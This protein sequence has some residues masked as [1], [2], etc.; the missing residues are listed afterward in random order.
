MRIVLLHPDTESIRLVETVLATGQCQLTSV[1][2][3]AELEAE[4]QARL[5]VP[6][7]TDWEQLLIA[8]DFDAVVVGRSNW[9]TDRRQEQLRKLAAAGMPLVVIHPACDM[10][11]GFELQM[12]QQDANGPIIPYLSGLQ[13]PL[14][15]K[16]AER[17]LRSTDAGN[18]S[19]QAVV[20]RR[21]PDGTRDVVL[22]EFARDALLLRRL[23][24]RIDRL[25]ALGAQP[26][27]PTDWAGLSI[28]MSSSTGTLARWSAVR[29][30]PPQARLMVAGGDGQMMLDFSNDPS[31]WVYQSSDADMQLDEPTG[32]DQRDDC[33]WPFAWLAERDRFAGPINEL[34]EDA[35]RA[36]ELSDTVEVSYRRGKTISLHH[37]QHSEEETFKSLMA[38]GGCLALVATLIA[39][40]VLAFLST[41]PIFAGP[42]WDR[43]PLRLIHPRMWP[44]YLLGLLLCF[45]GL[46]LFRLVFLGDQRAEPT[47]SGRDR[48]GPQ[49]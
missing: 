25:S 11:L 10:L 35:C 22:A 41:L 26:Y 8:T 12:I 13:H 48:E 33:S 38:A 30:T 17:L 40:P 46:Q 34:W 5:G 37:E 42:G 15:N 45:L 31:Q 2:D 18:G 29:G 16:L 32:F 7:S 23:V 39:F 36:V 49:S 4:V 27:P 28:Q 21:L 43:L 1:V 14:L 47:R 20:D 44:A 24:G 6:A 3:A 9:G 19:S